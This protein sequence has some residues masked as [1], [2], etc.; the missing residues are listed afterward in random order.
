[1][2]NN[3]LCVSNV[4]LAEAVPPMGRNSGLC[5]LAQIS[6]EICMT[7]GTKQLVE[8]FFNVVDTYSL[9]ASEEAKAMYWDSVTN[10]DEMT[11][12]PLLVGAMLHFGQ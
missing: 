7:G 10:C 1:M 9:N 8:D 5:L 4:V 12:Q 6:H 3:L 2:L 11:R